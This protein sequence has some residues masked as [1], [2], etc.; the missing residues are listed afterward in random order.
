MV[1]N[2]NT[3]IFCRPWKVFLRF[4]IFYRTGLEDLEKGLY[5]IVMKRSDKSDVELELDHQLICS[6]CSSDLLKSLEQAQ[7]IEYLSTA[8]LIILI[9]QDNP[10]E[11]YILELV[12]D[13]DDGCSY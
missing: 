6:S 11:C 10:L 3:S 8:Q 13:H 12:D 5:N 1:C 7:G 2:G 4:Q 9:Y